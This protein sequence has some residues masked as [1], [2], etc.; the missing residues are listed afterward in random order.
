MT[1][2]D[3]LNAA[4][5]VWGR[6]LYKTTSLAVL[7]K[8]L[9][10]SKSALYRHFSDKEDLMAAMDKRFFD[11]HAEAL[12][13]AFD[14]ALKTDQWRERL[15]IIMRFLTDYFARNFNYFIYILVNDS[16][17]KDTPSFNEEA[18]KNRGIFFDRLLPPVRH[19]PSALFLTGIAALF[20]TAR[21]HKDRRTLKTGDCSS[22]DEIR[23]FAGAALERVRRGLCSGVAPDAASGERELIDRIPYK[24][25]ETL[26]VRAFEDSVNETADPLIRAVAET[27]AEAGPW[28]ASMET[29]AKRSGLSKSG[30]YSHFK[31][32]RDMLSRLFMDEFE[33]IAETAAVCSALSERRE[34]RL[35]LAVFSIAEYLRTR[36]EILTALNW[37]RIQRLELDLSVPFRLYDFFTGLHDSAGV[38]RWALSLLVSVLMQRRTENVSGSF[39]AAVRKTFRFISLGLEGI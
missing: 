21:F 24:K 17:K 37:V 1:R 3:I 8:S 31:N 34:E 4:F 7:S 28:N 2:D 11:A 20:E 10:V 22:G 15:L 9:G 25:L 14:E 13:P 19:Q 30:L 35:Y 26:V 16:K 38:S 6:E 27:V 5:S 33:R 18:L 23:A 36:P 29:V 12:R 39:S 32:K